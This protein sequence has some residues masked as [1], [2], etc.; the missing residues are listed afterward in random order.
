MKKILTITPETD[1]KSLRGKRFDSII[2]DEHVPCPEGICDGSGEINDPQYDSNA[3]CY[4]NDGST[5]P[6]PHT[7]DL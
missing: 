1:P 3:H 2:I 5:K 7:L 6:C 4:I